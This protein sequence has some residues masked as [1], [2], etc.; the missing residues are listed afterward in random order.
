MYFLKTFLVFTKIKDLPKTSLLT[1]IFMKKYA[2]EFPPKKNTQ[3]CNFINLIFPR[4]LRKRLRI[5]LIGDKDQVLEPAIE[6]HTQQLQY[7]EYRLVDKSKY[8]FVRF[9]WVKRIFNC[10]FFEL[11]SESDPTGDHPLIE[12]NK[13]NTKF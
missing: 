2:K 8:I 6:L 13:K 5:T 11:V 3:I 1:P 4:F 12:V 7:P 9:L 10:R